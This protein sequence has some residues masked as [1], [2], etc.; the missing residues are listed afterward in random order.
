M[1][2]TDRRRLAPGARTMAAEIAALDAHIDDAIAHGVD[3]IQI[4]ERDLDARPLLSLVARAVARTTGTP[5]GVLVNDRADVACAAGAAGV[6]VP[7]DGAAAARV[8]SIGGAWIVGRS[9][10]DGDD[11]GSW[12]DADYALFGSVQSTVSKPGASPAGIDALGRAIRASAIPVLAIGGMT[13][14]AAAACATAGARGVAAIGAF[15]PQGSAPDA[16]GVAGAVAAFGAAGRR[17]AES[18]R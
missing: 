15:L 6:H 1:L 7:G 4:R 11:P 16:L 5:T 2:V 12:A 17:D 13:A 9:I 3:L 8:R 14:A 18:S 10:H